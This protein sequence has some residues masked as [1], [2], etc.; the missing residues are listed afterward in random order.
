VAG[1]H[2]EEV[3]GEELELRHGLAVRERGV[4]QHRGEVVAGLAPAVLQDPVQEG[5]G[6]AQEGQALLARVAL[7]LELRVLDPEVLV[8]DAQDEVLVLARDAQH[9]GDHAQGLAGGD[10]VHELALA[11]AVAGQLVEDLGGDGLEARLQAL[12]GPRGEPPGDELAVVAVLR[13]VHVDQHAQRGVLGEVVG[14]VAHARHQDE[15]AGAPELVGLLGNLDDVGVPRDRPEGLVALGLHPAHGG[16][17]PEARPGLVGVAVLAVD[18]G[19]DDVELAAE[20][21]LG[22]SAG[23]GHGG[24]SSGSTAGSTARIR[25][26]IL[27]RQ[28]A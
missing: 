10:A 6:L 19:G 22:G 5:G 1:H 4:G 24:S 2:D 7:A 26:A 14:V 25:T 28:A 21:R 15:A 20:G 27:G 9:L 16:L 13:R 3:Q 18:V 23:G 17:A 11:L 8:G 12:D